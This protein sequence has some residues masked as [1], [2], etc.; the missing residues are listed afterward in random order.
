MS[1]ANARL[2]ASVRAYLD[3]DW[4]LF[5]RLRD[6][7]LVSQRRRGSLPTAFRIVQEL[8]D[9]ARTLRPEW[10]TEADREADLEDH[11]RLAA[12]LARTASFQRSAKPSAPGLRPR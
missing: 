7:E 4:G 1:A 9:S 10:P 2:T 8:R 5:E 11:R 6:R 3:R 12:T